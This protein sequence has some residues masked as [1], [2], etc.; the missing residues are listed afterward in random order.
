MGPLCLRRA[1]LIA[2][3]QQMKSGSWACSFLIRSKVRR[4]RIEAVREA[5]AAHER[6]AVAAL[7]PEGAGGRGRSCDDGGT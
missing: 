3:K 4:V 2:S 6:D 1:A 5:Q 7:P